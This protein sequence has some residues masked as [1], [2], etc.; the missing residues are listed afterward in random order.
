MK[1]RGSSKIKYEHDIIPG[2]RNFLEQRIEPLDWVDSIFPGAIKRTKNPIPKFNIRFQYPTPTGAKLLAY[3]SGV[4]Q[5]VFVVT[6]EPHKLKEEI[7][8]VGR[9]R[10]HRRR[11]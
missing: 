8:K 4:V 2:L 7:E 9:E 11:D 6:K 1:H 3:H 5:E 10:G